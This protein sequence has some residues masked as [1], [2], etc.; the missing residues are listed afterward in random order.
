VQTQGATGDITADEVRPIAQGT[1][2]T[3]R[4][5]DENTVTVVRW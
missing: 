1:G 2:L 5:L 4:Y 3:Y